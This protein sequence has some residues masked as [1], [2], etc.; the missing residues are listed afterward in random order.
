MTIAA[1]KTSTTAS[2]AS[3][4]PAPPVVNGSDSDDAGHLELTDDE[5][6][7]LQAVFANL[8]AEDA[9]FIRRTL[10][11]VQDSIFITL[12]QTFVERAERIRVAGST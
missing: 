9:D 5:A 1:N 10:T 3:T 11:P 7:V 6:A 12:M 2:T 4:E 8:S